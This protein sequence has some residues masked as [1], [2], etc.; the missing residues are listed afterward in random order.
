M[1]RAIEKQVEKQTEK[2]VEQQKLK[3]P[4]A[5]TR[6]NPWLEA[7]SEAGNPF[8][9]LLKFVKGKWTIGDDE[10]AAGSEY[11]AHVDQLARGWVRSKN[12]VR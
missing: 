3:L 8:G 11:V 5:T 1:K 2:Q 10:I 6:D 4:A 7:A 12:V 9:K